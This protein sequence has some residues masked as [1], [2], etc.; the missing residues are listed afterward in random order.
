[1]YEAPGLLAVATAAAAR[2]LAA[3]HGNGTETA[4]SSEPALEFLLSREWS[5]FLMGACGS[6]AN[7]A[8][9]ASFRIGDKVP[10]FSSDSSAGAFNF[11]E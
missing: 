9:M 6:T 10:D 4:S 3:R 1:M 11:Y 2:R 7:N 5:T 8:T